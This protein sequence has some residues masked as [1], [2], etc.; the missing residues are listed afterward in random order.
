MAVPTYTQNVTPT[1]LTTGGQVVAVGATA[2]GTLDL[3]VKFGAWVQIALGRGGTTAITNALNI[4]CR[5]IDNGGAS[6]VGLQTAPL[7]PLASSLTA[8]NSTTV[9]SDSASGQAVLHLTSGTG[10]A[11]GQIICVQDSGG[12]ITRLEFATISKVA[13]NDLTLD[14]P[15]RYLHT[16]VQADTVRNQADLFAPI[17]LEGGALWEV[18]FDYGAEASAQSVTILCVAQTLDSVG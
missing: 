10:F 7:P 4:R 16:A 8:A 3:R 2:R 5:R 1:G 6:P 15:L 9:A 13:T 11:A 12:G 14:A 18:V 17:W